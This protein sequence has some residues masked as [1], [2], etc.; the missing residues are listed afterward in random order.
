MVFCYAKRNKPVWERQTPDDF[1]HMWNIN[2]YMDQEIVQ[3]LPG[4]GG[5][6]EGTAG[7]GE[8]SRGDRQ[9]IVYNWNLTVM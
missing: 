5:V 6:G 9:E 7:E 8:H 1:T 3:W 4:E 2:K